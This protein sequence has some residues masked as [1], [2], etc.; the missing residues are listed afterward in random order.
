[1]DEQQILER[2]IT[3]A[4]EGGWNKDILHL[5]VSDPSGMANIIL[6]TQRTRD[7]IYDHDF[8]KALWGSNGTRLKIVEM[9]RKMTDDIDYM[10]MWEKHLMQMVISKDRL[11][12]LGENLP[13]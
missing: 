10:P 11:K 2:A 4:I 3:K 12:Y 1:M 6:I 8:A 13:T 5:A 7:L 9:N